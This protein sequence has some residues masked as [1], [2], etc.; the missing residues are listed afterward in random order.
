MFHMRR[1]YILTSIIAIVT[2][3]G[4]T[5]LFAE[6][7]QKEPI[8]LGDTSSIPKQ[9]PQ[10]NIIQQAGDSIK[11]GANAVGKVA[12]DAWAGVTGLFKSDKSCS[13]DE[14]TKLRNNATNKE[15][16]KKTKL[17]EKGDCIV[18]LCESKYIPND[19]RTDC[20]LSEGSCKPQA[21]NA[22]A[23]ELKKG[24]C[25]ITECA[26]GYR[27]S[28]DGTQCEKAQLS[29]E[30]SKNK[31]AELRDNANNMKAKEQ[32]FENRMLGATSTFATGM[33]GKNLM[34]GLAEQKADQ[35]AEEDMKA[36]LATFVCDYGQGRNIKG[37]EH[38]IDLPGGND[39]FAI[40]NEYRA[41]AADL[42][43]R[44]EALGKQPG[45]ESEI[46]YDI[47][48]TGLY[49]D[50]ALGR[51][52][53]SYASISRA[54][55]DETGED[56]KAWAQ[57]KADTAS[58][59]KTGA[60]VAGAGVVAG[61]VGN[62]AINSGDKNKNK[63]DKIIADYDK[64]TQAV[65]TIQAKI[66]SVPDTQRSCSDYIYNN[67]P[68]SG[69]YPDC[70]CGD[71]AYFNT[72][73]SENDKLVGCIP[74]S[75]DMK[76]NDTK[77][78]CICINGKQPDS[79]GK[80][81]SELTPCSLT[82]D[83]V[84]TEN[85]KCTGNTRKVANSCVCDGNNYKDANGNCVYCNPETHTLNNSKCTETPK[86][87][88]LKPIVIKSDKFFN[89]SKA[90]FKNGN[91]DFWNEL[92]E[93][94][95][96]IAQDSYSLYNICI[97]GQTDPSNFPRN[98]KK[99]NDDLSTARAYAVSKQLA[100]KAFKSVKY[101]GTGPVKEKD[102]IDSSD[103]TNNI[104]DPSVSGKSKWENCRR[105]LIT[106]STNECP[107]GYIDSDTKPGFYELYK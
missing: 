12:T 47:S 32:S 23:G 67:T 71:N 61:V 91:T 5:P 29:E 107:D 86:K 94:I 35:A 57:Q 27:P 10:K 89:L 68:L 97:M 8:P 64:K 49:D 106:I 3:F 37:G 60:I 13:A 78:E 16:I 19:N 31:V 62:L 72:E 105:V 7:T 1:V 82:G 63:A 100:D 56:A 85:C 39:M 45:I 18:D 28:D 69:N 84:D 17:N 90:T 98:S 59:V 88:Q 104:C 51:Q 81:P 95:N 65:R 103:N 70:E 52:S 77:T 11:S 42:K 30:D 38:N 55:M 22:T 14:D 80:C 87:T 15:K 54:L 99:N 41:L 96:E 50:V 101:K 6:N 73:H 46:I 25:I 83:F 20:Q 93:Q 26:H 4:S 79:N 44:K 2:I 43:A 74:C 48:E 75:N 58:K 66:D 33:G 36:Y 76:V 40:V 92:S 21:T 24:K 53:G 34:S 9:T 102:T